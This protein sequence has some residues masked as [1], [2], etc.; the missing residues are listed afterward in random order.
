MNSI[1]NT[2]IE[3][4]SIGI[5]DIVIKCSRC[6]NNVI[7]FQ[8]RCEFCLST[9]F[10]KYHPYDHPYEQYKKQKM[11]SSGCV[12]RYDDTEWNY[13]DSHRNK[14]KMY[15]RFAEI[16]QRFF[17]LPKEERNK[18]YNHFLNKF[19]KDVRSSKFFRDF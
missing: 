5:S 6:D 16:R 7:L 19:L 9:D 3:N 1:K 14:N 10:W 11:Q 13:I 18:T 2:L 17:N 15:I 12:V 8:E 4:I